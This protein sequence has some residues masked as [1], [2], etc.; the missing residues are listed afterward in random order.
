MPQS[1]IH[2]NVVNIRQVVHE[3]S[4]TQNK[5]HAD[6]RHNTLRPPP[7]RDIIIEWDVKHANKPSRANPK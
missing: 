7:L 1:Y 2:A 3:I 6:A 5:I 4:C